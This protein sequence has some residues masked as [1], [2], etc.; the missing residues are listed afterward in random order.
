MRGGG[1]EVGMNW[2]KKIGSSEVYPWCSYCVY[3]MFLWC[4][5]DVSTCIYGGSMVYLWWFCG[6]SC[7]DK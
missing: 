3:G 1:S 6:V 7:V 5:C 2:R 4:I